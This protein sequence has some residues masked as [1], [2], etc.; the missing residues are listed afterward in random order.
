MDQTVVDEIV[1]DIYDP[2]I[3]D[4]EYQ[5]LMATCIRAWIR[6]AI[7]RGFKIGVQDFALKIE[8]LT[9]QHKDPN[10]EVVVIKK[11]HYS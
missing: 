3:E 4:P 9:K 10:N 5:T 8:T 11:N 7:H 2:Q 6:D 1:N